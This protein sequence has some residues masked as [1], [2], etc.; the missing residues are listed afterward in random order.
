MSLFS[1]TVYVQNTGGLEAPPRVVII[2]YRPVIT[3]TNHTRL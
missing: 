3:P 1:D 2:F